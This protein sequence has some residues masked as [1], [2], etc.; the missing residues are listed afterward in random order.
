MLVP[1]HT[2]RSFAARGAARRRARVADTTKGCRTPATG[3]L[4]VPRP[5]AA[6]SLGVYL[7]TAAVLFSNSA[8]AQRIILLCPPEAD[9]SL[10]E[11]FNRLRG[12]LSMHGF[13]VEVQNSA[14][15]ISPEN[16][17][18]RA[19]SVAAVASVSFVRSAVGHATADIKI[20]DRVTGKTTIRTIATPDG[21]DAASLLALRAVELLRA[22]LREFGAGAKT[23][24]DIVGAAPDR[25]SPSVRKWADVQ[26]PPQPSV[27]P[28]A[29]AP[30]PPTK[31]VPAASVTPAPVAAREASRE[32]DHTPARADARWSLHIDAIAAALL[33][34]KHFAYGAGVAAGYRAT[35]R[36]ELQLGV[37]MPWFGTEYSVP[38]AESKVHIA[39][40]AAGLAYAVWATRSV[41]LRLSGGLGLTRMTLYTTTQ[42]PVEPRT[43]AAGLLMPRI[44]TGLNIALSR[45]VFWQTSVTLA[46]LA[47]TPHLYLEER[48]FRVGLPIIQVSRGLGARF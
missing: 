17:A 8:Q 39:T 40:L 2:W 13:E 9:T 25:A 35:R 11:A 22:S 3:P 48:F 46:A 4:R 26:P 32:P 12:E 19:D 42:P 43:P 16:L 20:S 18:L 41:E 6:L 14:E 31:P 10:T 47:P 30:A 1:Q 21:T 37:E 38:R 7:F 29:A 23:P 45:A 27:P 15:A 33:P 28:E 36:V 24:K 5:L 34:G 44:G